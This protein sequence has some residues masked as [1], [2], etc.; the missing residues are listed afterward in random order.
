MKRTRFVLGLVLAL[1]VSGA[2]RAQETLSGLPVLKVDGT[3]YLVGPA[4]SVPLD[5]DVVDFKWCPDGNHLM[6]RAQSRMPYLQGILGKLDP[7]KLPEMKHYLFSFDLKTRRVTRLFSGTE[8]IAEFSPVNSKAA[9]VTLVSSPQEMGQTVLVQGEG[10]RT[11]INLWQEGNIQ[12]MQDAVYQPLV[13]CAILGSKNGSLTKDYFVVDGRGAQV[14]V[15]RPNLPPGSDVYLHSKEP[16]LI[17]SQHDKLAR[18]ENRPRNPTV[19]RLLDLNG[20]VT[21]ELSAEDAFKALP[22]P[23]FMLTPHSRPGLPMDAGQE[24]WLTSALDEKAITPAEGGLPPQ[25]KGHVIVPAILGMGQSGDVSPTEDKVAYVYG[26]SVFVREFEK[27]DPKLLH[28]L[29][30]RERRARA[31]SNV[32]QVGLALIMRASDWDE[33]LPDASNWSKEIGP[34][35]KNESISAEFIFTFTGPSDMTKIADPANTELGY[36]PVEG[37][38]AV[39]Y[40]DGHAKIVMDPK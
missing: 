1:A 38:R 25:E 12:V 27:I 2:V 13:L 16:Y 14:Q 24:L 35:L 19:F 18:E 26:G 10:S 8:A 6:I 20:T 40:A 11:P 7:S 36:I 29:E 4:A 22:E 21:R 34:Y 32:K 28:E 3:A 33:Q 9:L 31:L 30:E 37:G 39:V 17:L 23:N 5:Y 15:I